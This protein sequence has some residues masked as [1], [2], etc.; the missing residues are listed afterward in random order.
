V[1]GAREVGRALASG[2]P[3]ACLYYCEELFSGEAAFA[4]LERAADTDGLECVPM[5]ADAFL[6]AAYRE[7]PD[8]FLAVARRRERDLADFPLSEVP[9]LV[10]AV[11]I[12]KPGNLGAIL[13]TADAAGCD[14]LLMADPRCDPFNPNAVRAS[15]G[16]FF[17]LP[18]AAVSGGEVR[19]FLQERR[20]EPIL[21]TPTAGKL[22][23]E[24]DLSG[25]V[26][27]VLGTEDRGLPAE[28]LS[29]GGTRV[30][31]PMRG[32]TDSLN[33]SAMAAVALFEAVR[34]RA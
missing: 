33:V 15:Q 5:A 12:E 20:I 13:R 4:L 34:Q 30:N 6:R 32:V 1:E 16:A 24:A 18:F 25:P 11:G 9:L 17:H 29:S 14:G 8:G 3:L 2:W 26:A 31:L 28:W 21:T 10:I 23:Y 22:L 19:N 7:G 27:L